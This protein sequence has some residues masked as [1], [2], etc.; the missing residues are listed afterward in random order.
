MKTDSQGLYEYTL[1]QI[2]ERKFKILDNQTNIYGEGDIED[3]TDT[4]T[5]FEKKHLEKGKTIKYL[6]FVL[7]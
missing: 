4:Q 2:K 6:K 5:T 1:E 7:R 3:I